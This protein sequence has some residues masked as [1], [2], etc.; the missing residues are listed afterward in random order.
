MKL[1]RTGSNWTGLE[2]NK[3]NENWSIIEGSYNDVVENVSEKAFEQVVD[4]AKL[5]W[6][7][8]VDSF[9]DLPSS[10]SEG[11]ARMVRDTGKVYR[12]NGSAW[13]E[14]Q[15]IDAGPVNEVDGRLTAQLN[16]KADRS[17]ARLK[18][19]PI[20]LNDAS[21]EL[22]AA[23]EGGEGTTFNLLSIPRDY[24]VEPVK[25]TFARKG[26]NLFS[27]MYTHVM[28]ISGTPV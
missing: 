13:V 21:P 1:N 8:P 5:D 15:Q 18:N 23:I 22:L 27:G 25:T 11:E 9:N 2:R 6:K 12:F 28:I 26:K 20:G 14:I 7:E 16:N 3:I 17:E 10:A 4:S 19:V 24:S